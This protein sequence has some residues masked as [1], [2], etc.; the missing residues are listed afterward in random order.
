MPRTRKTLA[1]RLFLGCGLRGQ[2]TL[3]LKAW[4]L[5]GCNFWSAG[6]FWGGLA[7]LASHKGVPMITSFLLIGLFG[8]MALLVGMAL[9]DGFGSVE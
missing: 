5:N 1:V 6:V 9:E 4:K 7:S 3:L 2:S 8:T